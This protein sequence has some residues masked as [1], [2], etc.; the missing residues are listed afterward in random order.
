MIE[1]EK[2]SRDNPNHGEMTIMYSKDDEKLGKLIL[3]FLSARTE[4]RRLK[5]ELIK[6]K[7]QGKEHRL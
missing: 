7:R 4:Y 1:M 5:R 3:D 2:M 6:E